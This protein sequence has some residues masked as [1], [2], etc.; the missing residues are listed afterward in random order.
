MILSKLYKAMTF[1]GICLGL[2]SFSSKF[3]V[4]RLMLFTKETQSEHVVCE[5][6]QFCSAQHSVFQFVQRLHE[7]YSFSSK[8]SII[9]LRTWNETN[10]V[11]S[12][13]NLY[14]SQNLRKKKKK[15][16]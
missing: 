13:I 15:K 2:L 3:S 5:N 12:K 1:W 14:L 9:M 11:T 6:H 16:K 7:L 4:L 10:P 8:I